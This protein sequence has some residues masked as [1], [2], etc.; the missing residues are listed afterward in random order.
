M[1]CSTTSRA[2]RRKGAL[3]ADLSFLDGGRRPGQGRGGAG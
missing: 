2:T 3:Q 1:R